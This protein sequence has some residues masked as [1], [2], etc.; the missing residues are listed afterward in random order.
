M[1]V[2]GERSASGIVIGKTGIATAVEP[3]TVTVIV[4]APQ[5]TVLIVAC[6]PGTA[7]RDETSRQRPRIPRQLLRLHRLMTRVW[8]KPPC[9]FY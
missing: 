8:K 5:L 2:A 6:R 9:S 3:E 1:S 4:T 7:T